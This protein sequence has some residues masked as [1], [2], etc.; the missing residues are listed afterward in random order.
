MF[1]LINSIYI[2]VFLARS[3]LK[4]GVFVCT[5]GCVTFFYLKSTFSF[6]FFLTIALGRFLFPFHTGFVCFF[7]GLTCGMYC[8]TFAVSLPA[9]S[10]WHDASLVL[11][12]RLQ[13]W[14]SPQPEMCRVP[15]IVSN[16]LHLLSPPLDAPPLLLNKLRVAH[17]HRSLCVIPAERVHSHLCSSPR[18]LSSARGSAHSYSGWSF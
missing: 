12:C 18:C 13:P 7:A 11:A 6:F 16:H 4:I 17:S 10:S 1:A 3:N 9:F 8:V 2:T 15:A 5:A 14:W